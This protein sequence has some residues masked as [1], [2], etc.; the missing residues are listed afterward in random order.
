M[1]WRDY[2]MKYIQ[3]SD[4][5][6]AVLG[7]TARENTRRYGISN[8]YYCGPALMLLALNNYWYM[9]YSFGGF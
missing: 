2:A 8:G 6:M 1:C 7:A 5:R 4:E 9:E 3:V